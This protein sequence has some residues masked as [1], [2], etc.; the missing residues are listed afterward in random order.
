MAALPPV[1]VT[2]GTGYIGQP[3]IRTLQSSGYDVRGLVRRGSES[4]LPPGAQ[5]VIG[6]AL[7]PATFAQAIPAGATVV[8]LVGTPHPS[9]S[10][11]E[12]FQ[13]VDLASIRATVT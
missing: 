11:T 7:D 1:F 9:P 6:K 13:R 4:R 12:E 10:K 3:L 5:I 2:G 8:H